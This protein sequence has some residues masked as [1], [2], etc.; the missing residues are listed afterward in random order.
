[1]KDKDISMNVDIKES[2][3]RS[4]VLYHISYKHFSI[5]FIL[6]IWFKVA[7]L[8]KNVPNF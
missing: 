8:L 7:Y 2:A 5:L 3:N 1:M 4:M 6:K